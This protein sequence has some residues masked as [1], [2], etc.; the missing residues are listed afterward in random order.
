MYTWQYD[1]AQVPLALEAS[2]TAFRTIG[3]MAGAGTSL[4]DLGVARELIGDLDGAAACYEE[5]LALLRG[6]GEHWSL[7]YTLF[8]LGGLS[9]LRG[10]DERALALFVEAL[11]HLRTVRHQA[12]IA[13]VEIELARFDHRRGNYPQA[14]TRLREAIT[15]GRHTGVRSTVFGG[16]SLVGI[17]AVDE[18][19]LGTG[20]RLIGAGLAHVPLSDYRPADRAQ[21][22]ASLTAARS[23]L[24][25]EEYA[26]I[27]AEGQAMTIDKAAELAM[28]EVD[29]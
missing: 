6:Q 12:G 13:N 22:E 21:I 27:W 7:G 15:A 19:A 11:A 2:I 25:D 16:V 29:L 18:G 20:L 17:I 4:R 23:G 10:E 1:D 3:D 14:R 9:A 24:G 26:R 5:S 28:K 8:N